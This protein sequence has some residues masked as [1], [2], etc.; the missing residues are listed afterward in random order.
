MTGQ[1]YT[2][3]VPYSPEKIRSSVMAMSADPIAYSV[4]ALDRQRGKVT[5]TQLKSQAFFTQHYLEPAKQLVRQVLGGQKADDAL[6]CRVAGITPEKLAEAHTI[7]TPPRRGMM[8]GRAATPAEYTADQKREAQ[9][10]AEVERTVT[11]IQNYKRALEESPEMEMRSILNALAGGY[12]APTS[13]GDAVANPQAV[14]TGRNLYAVNAETTP[15]EQ[16]WAKGKELAENTLAQYKKTHGD[17]PRKVS[18]TFWSSEFIE[19]EGATIAQVL[20][21]LGVEPVRDAYGRVSDLRLIPSE[22]L[23]RPAWT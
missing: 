1:L 15:S 10:I 18:Y 8:M 3:G 9:A 20:Y 12:V 2:T 11:N 14:P 4:A 21:M 6:V 5:D 16:A 19:S 23:G 13:G 17:Y 22:Q 7:L